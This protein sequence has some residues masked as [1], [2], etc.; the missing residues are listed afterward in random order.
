MVDLA[1]PGD[2]LPLRFVLSEHP[3]PACK[4]LL[5][6]PLT[7]LQREQQAYAM[8][9]KAKASKALKE[10]DPGS[11]EALRES[12]AL[13]A[14]N[15]NTANLGTAPG[16]SNSNEPAPT[17]IILDSSGT[18]STSTSP[19]SSSSSTAAGFNG[20][21]SSFAATHSHGAVPGDEL[22]ACPLA[23]ALVQDVGARVARHRGGALFVD[24]GEAHALPASL[25]GFWK[26]N[27]QH[28]LFRPGE[29]NL[30]HVTFCGGESGGYIDVDFEISASLFR[31]E[32]FQQ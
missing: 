28:V 19:N 22:E 20:P 32:N 1:P 2:P 23:C 31:E 15:S 11:D 5:A 24:Y 30:T 8:S 13:A 21:S 10:A 14:A 27:E 16:S 25:R 6:P 17:K 4:S 29:V 9:Q 7:P 3:T 18:T 12:L 26:H